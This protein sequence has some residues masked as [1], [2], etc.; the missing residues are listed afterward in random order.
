MRMTHVVTVFD[1]VD[2]DGRRNPWHSIQPMQ[3][4]RQIR[5]ILDA[6]AIALEVSDMHRVES[7]QGRE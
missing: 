7:H 6:I 1:V 4:A 5:E 3:L 2:I